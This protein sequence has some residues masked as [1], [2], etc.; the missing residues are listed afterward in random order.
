MGMLMRRHRVEELRV[1]EKEHEV[2]DAL[3]E[4][5]QDVRVGAKTQVESTHF[6]APP[7]KRKKQE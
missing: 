3:L 1:A 4:A 2:K 5:K 7:V 6:E